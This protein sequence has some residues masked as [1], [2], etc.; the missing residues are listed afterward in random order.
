MR[1]F[2]QCV[3]HVK[4]KGSTNTPH[5]V[6]QG[7]L[8]EQVLSVDTEAGDTY[9]TLR[10]TAETETEAEAQTGRR[11]DEIQ[12]GVQIC[13]NGLVQRNLNTSERTATVKF[14]N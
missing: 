13:S 2:F 8:K 7:V 1:L 6:P 3:V 14:T 4:D 12:F 10:D 5:T 11:A 9:Q